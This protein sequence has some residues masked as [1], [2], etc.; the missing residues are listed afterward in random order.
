MRLEKPIEPWATWEPCGDEEAAEALARMAGQAPQF[1]ANSNLVSARSAKLPFYATHRLIELQFVRDHGPE[2]AF[3]LHGPDDTRWLDGESG[4]MRD[5]NQAESLALTD[6]TVHHYVRFFLYFL[7]ADEL[8]FVLIETPSEITLGEDSDDSLGQ[9][10]GTSDAE[11]SGLQ[12][13][14]VSVRSR[15]TQLTTRTIDESGRWVV[16]GSVAYNGSLF[17]ATLAVSADGE[18][19]M[20]DDEA[21]DTLD[22]LLVPECPSLELAAN[23]SALLESD[24]GEETGDSTR[25]AR[26]VHGFSDQ[27]LAARA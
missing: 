6:T 17:V 23:P 13:R 18:V 26:P 10:D 11:V 12:I 7:R 3:V 19:E 22:Q 4:P 5:T 9:D 2:R 1:F 20:I 16:D 21:V 25:R 8:A 24:V 27:V 15:V 14:C